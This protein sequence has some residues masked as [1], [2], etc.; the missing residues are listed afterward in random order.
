MPHELFIPFERGGDQTLTTTQ[1]TQL[2]AMETGNNLWATQWPVSTHVTVLSVSLILKVGL[3]I[4][5]QPFKKTPS[6]SFTGNL[7]SGWK[8]GTTGPQTV[9]TFF[10]RFSHCPQ[11]WKKMSAMTWSLIFDIIDSVTPCRVLFFIY[12]GGRCLNGFQQLQ[13]GAFTAK[14]KLSVRKQSKAK[15]LWHGSETGSV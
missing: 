2:C 8:V 1:E 6:P 7:K 3:M 12:L 13:T 5:R 9:V 10:Q 15:Y 4:I 14:F 11:T